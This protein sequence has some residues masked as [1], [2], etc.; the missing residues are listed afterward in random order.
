MTSILLTNDDGYDSP[1]IKALFKSLSRLGDVTIVAPDRDNSAVSHSITMNR[2]LRL[3]TIEQN[4]IAV[5]GTPADCVTLAVKKVLQQ[6]PDILVSG[7][8]S[9]PNIGDD[10]S[11]SGTVSAAIEGTMFSIPSLAV[12]L[13]EGEGDFDNA[14]EITAQ[15]AA[16]TIEN[17]LP[18]NTLLNVN[19][20]AEK[21][22]KG[23]KITR[24]GRRFWNDSI[25]ESTDPWGRKIYWI[26]GGTPTCDTA[27]DTD[28][29]AI[30]K[31]YISITPIQLDKT[32]HEGI[33][34]LKE[35]WKLNEL[36]GN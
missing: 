12:S 17:G 14:A 26:G 9:G 29:Y 6:K 8:N 3:K 15:I 31:G 4:I 10:I 5:D 34:R 36:E 32:N 19:I 21:T 2:P 24:Q 27:E 11:Y 30:S 22:S 35:D 7:I 16:M 25:Q 18:A 28:G 20:P 1:G 23:I 13:S 33:F